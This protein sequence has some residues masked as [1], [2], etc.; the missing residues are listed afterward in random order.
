[1]TRRLA[2]FLALLSVALVRFAAWLLD[3]ADRLYA[4]KP[5]PKTKALVLGSRLH[6]AF[7]PR[8]KTEV[9]P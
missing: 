5:D 7:H 4:S 8:N 3:R 6:N 1:M 2:L 9:Q